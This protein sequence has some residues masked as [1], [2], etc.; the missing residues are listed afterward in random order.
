M[1]RPYFVV[2]AELLPADKGGRTSSL[3][4]ELRVPFDL[5]VATHE[6]QKRTA[7]LLLAEELAP[8]AH[9]SA[10]LD[11]LDIEHWDRVS[12][13][14]VLPLMEG[15]H[16]MGRVTVNECVWPRAFTSATAAF[17][18]AAHDLCV[19]VND[20]SSHTLTAR[21]Q[22]ARM[23][24]VA[25][26]NAALQLPESE[27]ETEGDAPAPALPE[28]WPGFEKH[29]LY[30]EICD[31]YDDEPRVAGELTDDIIDVYKDVRRGLSFWEKGDLADA[32]WEWR[33]SFESHWGDHAID[34]LRA[35]HRA[36]RR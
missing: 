11:P 4:G 2:R 28:S 32:V 3:R 24:L 12:L 14:S 29:E 26:Y 13:G 34:A 21:V 20:A 9:V 22:T 25:L 5:G 33:F 6:T 15:S 35:L 19:F 17:A 18:R 10:R 31:P 36:A 8:G 7:R 23:L 1:A 30:W 27:C 16:M